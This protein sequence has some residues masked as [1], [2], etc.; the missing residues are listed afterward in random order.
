MLHIF[1]GQTSI[2]AGKAVISQWRMVLFGVL[3]VA[4]NLLP[5]CLFCSRGALSRASY[6]LQ[7]N[8]LLWDLIF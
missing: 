8:V 7:Y 4:V 5:V 1:A 6:F 3:F 2:M